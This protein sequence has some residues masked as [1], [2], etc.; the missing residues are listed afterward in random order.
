MELDYAH[1][2]D[3]TTMSMDGKVS[4]IGIFRTIHCPSL[5]AV[6]PLFFICLQL[7]ISEDDLGKE[8]PVSVRI[9]S[10]E[11]AEVFKNAGKLG[12]TPDAPIQPVTI[13]FR[14]VNLELKDFGPY[15]VEIEVAG[16]VKTIPLQVERVQEPPQISGP[17]R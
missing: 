12:V 11:G 9:I 2:A 17:M 14:V 8:E 1:L 13:Q 5:P 4:I 16:K 3:Y 10:P 7:N 6:H 15:G